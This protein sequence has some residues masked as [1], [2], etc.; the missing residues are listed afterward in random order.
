MQMTCNTSQK[1][2]TNLK[3]SITEEISLNLY[4]YY[5]VDI[6][7]Q[8]EDRNENSD[9]IVSIDSEI[10]SDE[11]KIYTNFSNSADVTPAQLF[12]HIDF[13]LLWLIELCN[14]VP[15]TVV[16]SAYK[17]KYSVDFRCFG[18]SF[19][20]DDIYL[21]SVVTVA[22]V[23]NAVGRILWGT[24]VDRFS[25]KIPLCIISFS[26]AVFLLTF[27]HIIPAGESGAKALFC[28]YGIGN[29]LF[30]SSVSTVA[31]AT[32]GSM[33]GSTHMAVNYG[34]LACARAV[35]C[36]LC[37]FALTYVDA[38]KLYLT[39]FTVCGFT[40]IIA[41]FLALFI[42]DHKISKKLDCCSVVLGPVAGYACRENN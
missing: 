23:F 5:Y 14:S 8:L 42:D 24:L 13:Y 11:L 38:D 36:P 21:S 12:H 25:Y 20:S 22:A 16:T 35:G 37:A 29:F 27:P 39:Q 10:Q 1:C 31:P 30:L 40:C 18:Q 6:F 3:I 34:I 26:W 2:T 28:I 41:F 9:E 32:V 19:I 15:L 17:F 7:F 33:F 4:S